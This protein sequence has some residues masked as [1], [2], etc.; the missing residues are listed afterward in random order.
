[1]SSD[2]PNTVLRPGRTYTHI[3][4]SSSSSSH[5]ESL[6]RPSAPRESAPL[7]RR[8][9]LAHRASAPQS[10][11]PQASS[12]RAS[13]PLDRRPVSAFRHRI[14][15][16]GSFKKYKRTTQHKYKNIMSYKNAKRVYNNSRH[17]RSRWNR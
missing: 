17:R 1:M 14:K 16:G 5:N 2:Q 9:A 8:P 11:A 3:S 13:A 10:S 7:D 12:P 15:T 6:H 4:S